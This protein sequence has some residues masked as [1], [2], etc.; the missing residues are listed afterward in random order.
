MRVL[1]ADGHIFEAEPMFAEV[2]SEFYERRPL[3]MA[4]PADAESGDA[5]R[6]WL[7]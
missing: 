4:L 3:L 1:D 2:E 7:I 6:V 5:N